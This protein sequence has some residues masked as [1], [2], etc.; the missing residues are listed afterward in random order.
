MLNARAAVDRFALPILLALLWSSGFAQGASASITG[1][2][3]D[4]SMFIVQTPDAIPCRDSKSVDP[5]DVPPLKPEYLPR[6]FGW[7]K[8]NRK[9][10]PNNPYNLV[11]G[12][13]WEETVNDGMEPATS[14]QAQAQV[15]SADDSSSGAGAALSA[16]VPIL[17]VG[18]VEAQNLA[19]IVDLRQ[20]DAPAL[21]RDRGFQAR[22]QIA[23]SAAFEARMRAHLGALGGAAEGWVVLF[24]A[25]GESGGAFY[26]NLTF[27]QAG[28]A[29]HPDRS[30]ATQLGVIRGR[31]GVI[32]DGSRVLGYVV[33]PDRLDLSAPIDIYWNDLMVTATLQP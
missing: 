17:A 18:D 23:R 11:R 15:H 20:Q 28:V 22:L 16:D 31:L 24:T 19:M 14:G 10:D 27:V 7:E 8:F 12:Q 1:V 5:S 21:L 2:C 32:P 30:D 3:P 13:T 6:R 29:F 26:G 9:H 4:G 33:L 25:D